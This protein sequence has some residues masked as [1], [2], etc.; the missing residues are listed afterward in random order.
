MVTVCQERGL[1]SFAANVIDSIKDV[2]VDIDGMKQ[3]GGDCYNSSRE[4]ATICDTTTSKATEIIDFG[5]E[6]KSA[7][8]GFTDGVDS[9]DITAISRVVTGDKLT[10][11]LKTVTEMDDLAL[12]CVN[13]SLKMI[14]SIGAG[15]DSLPDILE[16]KIDHRM[17]NAKQ[18]GSND[19][20]SELQDLDTDCRELEEAVNSVVSANPFT[21]IDSFQNAFDN[22][23]S[24]GKLC[25]DM[26]DNIRAFA[27][28]VT[29]VSDAI[30]NFKLG[31]MIGKISDL[32]KDIWRCL[33]L[34]DLIRSFAEAAGRLI[35][36]IMNVIQSLKEKIDSFDIDTYFAN[37]CGCFKEIESLN[38]TNFKAF[39]Q[40]II[41]NF[42]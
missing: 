39:S 9:K 10:A 11:A 18:K 12:A 36:W 14:D 34:S 6:M 22:V 15:V 41:K 3:A 42:A 35:K 20:D 4:A 38:M 30:Q 16:K 21:A 1:G 17:E 8:A 23:V 13:Q 28:D 27:N 19:G 32:I 26:F 24:K 37:Y 2:A 7:L 40:G 33:R 29:G 25:N 5:L 31:K